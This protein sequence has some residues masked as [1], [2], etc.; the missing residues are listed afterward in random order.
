MR[1][2]EVYQLLEA[3]PIDLCETPLVLVLIAAHKAKVV[4]IAHEALWNRLKVLG[5][6]QATRPVDGP[7]HNNPETQNSLLKT[8]ALVIYLASS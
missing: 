1:S 5:S 3:S 4:P 6:E 7:C 8:H 2:L